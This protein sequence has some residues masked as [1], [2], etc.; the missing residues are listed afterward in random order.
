MIFKRKD[1]MTIAD[2]RRVT[3]PLRMELTSLLGIFAPSFR[4]ALTSKMMM[5]A[6]KLKA[7]K[8]SWRTDTLDVREPFKVTHALLMRCATSFVEW[9]KAL[10]NDDLEEAVRIKIEVQY[11]MDLWTE[12]KKLAEEGEPLRQN[13]GRLNL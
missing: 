1:E 7:E 4:K 11:Y 2:Y 12:A 13:D 10:M 8:L 3:Y 6:K 9:T 5:K